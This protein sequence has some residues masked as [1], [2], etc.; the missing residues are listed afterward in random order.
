MRTSLPQHASRYFQ[1]GD[2]PPLF[3]W[4]QRT[5]YL[6]DMKMLRAKAQAGAIMAGQSHTFTVLAYITPDGTYSRVIPVA[7]DV[8]A[9]G[10]PEYG[11]LQGDV[12]RMNARKYAILSEAVERERELAGVRMPGANDP[13]WCGSGKKYRNCHGP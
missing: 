11:E 3:V 5:G 13:C 8:P 12:A 9:K 4:L 6:P 10:T 1:I 7:V 2:D